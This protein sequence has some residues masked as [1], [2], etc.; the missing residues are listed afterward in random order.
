M[1]RTRCPQCSSEWNCELWCVCGRREACDRENAPQPEAKACDPDKHAE[2]AYAARTAAA[3]WWEL[4]ARTR[5]FARATKET[6]Y[7]ARAAWAAA[8]EWEAR[9]ADE[10]AAM[11]ASRARETEV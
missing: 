10:L 4:K 5:D 7:A 11:K 1:S 2:E 9:C 3:A 8:E 6:F